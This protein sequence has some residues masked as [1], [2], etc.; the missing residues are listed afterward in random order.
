MRTTT[1]ATRPPPRRATGDAQR[2]TLQFDEYRN[3]P[4]VTRKRLW[5]ETVE[6]VLADNRKVVGGDGRQLIYVPMAGQGTGNAP[7]LLTPE[8]VSPTVNATTGD[9]AASRL[10]RPAREGASR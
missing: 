7:P 8:I 3:A 1:R 4:E 10:P 9:Q 5:L 2:F 6:Q